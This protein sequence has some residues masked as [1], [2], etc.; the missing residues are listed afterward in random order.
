[1]M[2]VST[3]FTQGGGAPATGLLLA[4][5]DLFLWS[6]RKTTGVIAL[7]WNA[8]NPTEE[9]G[10][11]IYTREY[12]GEN[13]ELYDY[14]AYANY[15]G[16]AVLDSDHAIMNS[17]LTLDAHSIW[18]YSSK[19]LTLNL[20]MLQTII[21]GTSISI[22]RGDTLDL[23]VQYLGDITNRSKLWFTVKVDKDF[24]D[25][26]ADIMIEETAGLQYINRAGAAI[27][28]NGSITVIDPVSGSISID[29]A[30]SETAKLLITGNF[31][32]D[33]QVL[34]ATGVVTTLRMGRATIVG[35]MTRSVL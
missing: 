9:V 17:A 8:V 26:S 31:Y 1:M 10:G 7:L 24:P 15:T 12:P 29:L 3:V 4:D 13:Y 19:Q 18:S 23:D 6:R 16:I 21:G 5:I 2:L 33:I 22:L 28:A 34:Y 25:G 20:P 11:G 14:L 32:Y 27:P 35:D 30:A